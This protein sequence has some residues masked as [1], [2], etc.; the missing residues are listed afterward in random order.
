MTFGD[1]F[2]KQAFTGVDA[3]KVK[4]FCAEGDQVC[5]GAFSITPAHLS[6]TS[7]G[8]TLKGAQFI[9]GLAA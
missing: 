2:Q 3:N 4:I 6:Y 5:A 7:S 8:D 9:A 1:P